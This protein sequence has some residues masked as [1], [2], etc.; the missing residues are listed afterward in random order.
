MHGAVNGPE[1]QLHGWGE[2]ISI[3]SLV[4]TIRT[5]R[6]PGLYIRQNTANPSAAIGAMTDITNVTFRGQTAIRLQR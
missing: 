2:A 3:S 5:A 6:I 4:I 1:F